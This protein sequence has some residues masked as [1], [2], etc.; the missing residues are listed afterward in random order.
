[1][2]R[3]LLTVGINKLKWKCKLM[4]TKAVLFVYNACVSLIF[5]FPSPFS[6]SPQKKK[7]WIRISLIILS[8]KR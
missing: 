6:L 5:S 1:M 4:L 2:G 8:L 3:P 7:L